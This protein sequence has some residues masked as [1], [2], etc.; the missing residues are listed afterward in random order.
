MKAYFVFDQEKRSDLFVTPENDRMVLADKDTMFQFISAQ[1]DFS[2]WRGEPLNNISP[3]TLGVV[4]ASR[5]EDGDV[6]I[7]E[8]ALWQERMAFLLGSL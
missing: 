2:Q 3:D 4:V 1:P 6:C 8:E 7:I 5:Q